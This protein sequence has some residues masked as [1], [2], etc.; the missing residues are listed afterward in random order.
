VDRPKTTDSV[1]EVSMPRSL[2]STQEFH[3]LLASILTPG[4][5]DYAVNLLEACHNGFKCSVPPSSHERF[6]E[7][8]LSYRDF[9]MY[10]RY[11]QAVCDTVE[12][13]SIQFKR[14]SR[15]PAPYVNRNRALVREIRR[16]LDSHYE[17][18]VAEHA[19]DGQEGQFH[20]LATKTCDPSDPWEEWGS[21]CA[22]YDEPHSS[23]QALPEDTTIRNDFVIVR[24]RRQRRSS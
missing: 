14:K 2:I 17:G 12:L 1:K 19:K 15:F 5:A 22:L 18:V 11:F 9:E 16:I 8:A 23:G 24:F 13:A 21:E 10:V 4:Q 7:K 3:K 6:F 20:Y